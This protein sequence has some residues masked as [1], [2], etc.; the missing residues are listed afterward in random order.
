MHVFWTSLYEL[1]C[2]PGRP[3]YCFVK[4]FVRFLWRGSRVGGLGLSR[5]YMELASKCGT[6]YG[7][8]LAPSISTHLRLSQTT[9]ACWYLVSGFQSTVYSQEKW[10]YKHL[11]LC[12]I[13]SDSMWSSFVWLQFWFVLFDG[14]ILGHLG[15]FWGVLRI[16]FDLFLKSQIF[17]IASSL[18][19]DR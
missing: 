2:I 7:N 17:E 11:F 13:W 18:R 19:G 9:F 3:I 6:N 8:S 4:I 5:G 10:H 15:L 12:L 1:F 16:M 14:D